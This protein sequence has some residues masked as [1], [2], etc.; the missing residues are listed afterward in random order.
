MSALTPDYGA[1]HPLAEE[2]KVAISGIPGVPGQAEIAFYESDPIQDSVD[3]FD[4]AE[5]RPH[6]L[7]RSKTSRDWRSRQYTNNT[8]EVAV[9][10][11]WYAAAK[12]G[13]AGYQ[14]DVAVTYFYADGTPGRVVMLKQ[15][16]P[17]MRNDAASGQQGAANIEWSFKY[18]K[19]EVIAV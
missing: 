11:T 12:S 16:F 3:T 5:G 4:T 1:D 8:D 2:V 19:A 18:H 17:V 7:G 10:E 14:R 15:C 9:M 13:K 6:S